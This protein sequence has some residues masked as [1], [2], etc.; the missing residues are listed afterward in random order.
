MPIL[1]G[2]VRLIDRI[3]DAVGRG[4]SWLTVA[5]VLIVFTVVVLRYVFSIGWIAMQ[6][7]YVWI[8]GTVFMLGAAYTLLHDGHVRIDLIYRDA[9]QRYKSLVNLLGSL[10]LVLPV[11][12][13]TWDK[14]LP[15]VMR[16]WRRLESSSEVGG[17][18]GL[19]LL[20]TIVLVFCVL[21]ALQAISLALRSI[22]ELYGRDIPR[23]GAGDEPE[24]GEGN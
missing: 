11:L 17:L 9:S 6:E 10:F 4:V 21:F 16:S 15:F 13:I 23:V 19:Y 3:N 20:K 2:L 8:H 1:I 12:W 7:I 24:K 18:P 5:M 22:A 14:G